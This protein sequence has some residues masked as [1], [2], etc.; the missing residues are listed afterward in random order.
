[1]VLDLMMLATGANSVKMAVTRR[2]CQP[3]DETM[4]EAQGDKKWLVLLMVNGMKKQE[5][6]GKG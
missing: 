1:M 5:I 3:D 6:K 4:G 2:P